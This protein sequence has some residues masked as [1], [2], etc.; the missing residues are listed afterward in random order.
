MVSRKALVTGLS[1]LLIA[2]V[3]CQSILQRE[4]SKNG[5]AAISDSASTTTQYIGAVAAFWGLDFGKLEGVGLVTE[6]RGTGSNPPPSGQRDYLIDELKT[7]PEIEN[8]MSLVSSP[9]TSM[10]LVK[11]LVPPGAKKGD[12]FDL[13]VILPPKPRLETTSLKHGFLFKTRMR[14]MVV[15]GNSVK[16]GSVSAQGRGSVL[17][18]SLFEPRKDSE[19]EVRGVILGGGVVLDDRTLGLSIRTEDNPIRKATSMSR[20]INDRFT[21]ITRD[22]RTG[23]AT[24][25]SD[26]VIELSIPENYRLNI[27]RY[28]Q[29]IAQIAYDEPPQLRVNRLEQL[30]R[31]LNQPVTCRDAA[32]R[33][34]AIGLEGVPAL[35]R[36]LLNSDPEI[37][38]QAAEALSYLGEADG[39]D[40]LLEA[41]SNSPKSRWHALTAL[42]ASQSPQAAE[43]LL[44][45]MSVESA[46][47]RYG[48]FRAFQT[49]SPSDPLAKGEWLADDFYFHEIPSS[50]PPMV[51]LT[52]SKR[53]EVA[54]FG[55]DHQFT[56]DFIFVQNGLTVRADG[57]GSLLMIRYLTGQ[58][59]ERRVCSTNLADA[60]RQ[61]ASLNCSYTEMVEL[62]QEARRANQLTSRVAINAV[63]RINQERFVP[64]EFEVVEAEAESKGFLPNLF[65]RKNEPESGAEELLLEP[66]SQNR[67]GEASA[68][69]SDADDLLPAPLEPQSTGSGK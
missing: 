6:L 2:S 30:D 68:E 69:E 45:L 32:L 47:T 57:K 40:V 5:L 52:R 41:A 53:P 13:E 65:G 33:L 35:R 55:K 37:R 60:I 11:G 26:K 67:A 43:A 10:V 1:C 64:D 34:E 19:N 7:H 18:N 61:L 28:S 59:E 20:A 16:K 54:L 29:V 63:P 3:G 27:G 38:F 24:P 22:G 51:H 49:R 48:A 8:A 56:D 17:V 25:K 14:P 58:Q 9:D 62:L 21:T 23:V 46:E 50:G 4:D 31:E 44:S 15:L 42:A 12:R 66:E 39:I 36:G